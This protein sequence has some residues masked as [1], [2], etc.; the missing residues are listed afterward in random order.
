MSGGGGGGGGATNLRGAVLTTTAARNLGCSLG[1]A[2]RVSSLGTGLIIV[3]VKGSRSCFESTLIFCSNSLTLASLSVV[4]I[5]S[6]P[7][8]PLTN[9][10]LKAA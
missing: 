9:G 4:G 3:L 2:K 6:S 7:F 1:L 5:K 8:C 10:A